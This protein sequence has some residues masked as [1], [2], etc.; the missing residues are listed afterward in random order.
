MM[1]EGTRS[2]ADNVAAVSVAM[3]VLRGLLSCSIG[4]NDAWTRC[5]EVPDLHRLL[6]G[7]RVENP[8]R[9]VN[10]SRHLRDMLL[11]SATCYHC[12][13]LGQIPAT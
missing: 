8:S 7:S 10:L 13:R 12:S 1:K 5:N 11:V 6:R 2:A 4:L 9:Q 3:T